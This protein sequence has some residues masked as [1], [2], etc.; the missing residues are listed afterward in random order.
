MGSPE[1]AA[2]EVAATA[3]SVDPSP[4]SFRADIVATLLYPV[5]H[6]PFR[7]L[8][9]MAAG[10]SSARRREVID[11]ALQSRTRRDDMLAGFRGG[12]YA[13]DMV[14]D[15]G[16][17]RDLHRHRRCQQFR[18]AYTGELGFDAGA[19]GEIRLRRNLSPGHGL[20]LG[21]DALAA[22]PGSHYLLPFGGRCRF[23]FK[24]DSP[25]PVHLQTAQRSE[26][27]LQLSKCRLGDEAQNG[28]A[29]AGIGPVVEATPPG[30]KIP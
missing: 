28:G 22:A 19:A 1:S 12:L 24:M 8:Y 17:Y 14:I 18:Q 25:R 15:I 5:T 29:G 27:A 16:A 13:Y 2:A 4:R 9:E 10:W 30:S 3:E 20:C 11:V 7:E 23:L 26:R 21:G 6:R